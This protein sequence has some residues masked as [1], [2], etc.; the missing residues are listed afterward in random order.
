MKRII[1]S[2]FLITIVVGV[3]AQGFTLDSC[4]SLTIVNNKKI[5]EAQLMIE[6]AE[7]VKKNAFTKYFPT[8][9]GGAVAM[10]SADYLLKEDI[11]EMNLPVYDGN[12]VNL[13][14]PTQFAYFPGMEL[15]VF[16]YM[17]IGYVAAVEPIYMGGRVRY[18]NKL[19]ALG[20]DVNNDKLAL[21]QDEELLKTEEHFWTIISLYE[22]MKTIESYDKML[23]N[24]HNDVLVAYQEGLILKS[25]LLEVELSQNK[26]KAS[27]L[28]LENAITLVSMALCQQVGLDYDP[29]VKFADNSFASNTNPLAES[30]ADSSVKRRQEYHMLLKAIEAEKLQ[31]KMV[32]GEYLPQLA[33]GVQGFYL[34]MLD[35]QQTNAMAF[36][37]LNIP[38]SDWWGGSHKIKEHKI[39]I[40]IAENNLD[41]ASEMMELQIKKTYNDMIESRNQ[42]EIANESVEK[43]EEYLKVS[44]DN[45]DAGLSSTSDLL[46]AQAKYQATEVD[47]V[48]AL[49]KYQIKRARYMN[50]I[51]L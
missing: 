37:T 10:K 29:S 7:Q 50:A 19:A 36:A 12:P 48:N 9:M 45:Y 33:V 46:K 20:E 4:K 23:I 30:A 26:L 5:K 21:K 22:K 51:N 3:N 1:I 39:K 43:A 34:D 16:D 49:T 47:K 18:G 25:D 44:Q 32:R 8:V 40:E 6:E 13:Q 31:T 2:I 38:I 27:R 11:P 35:N 42:I 24:L 15:N 28:Q 14:T 17:N 41:H